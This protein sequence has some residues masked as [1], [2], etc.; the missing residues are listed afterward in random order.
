MGYTIGQILPLAVTLMAGPLPMLVILLILVSERAAAKGVAFVCGR[1]LGVAVCLGVMIVLFSDLG[2]HGFGHRDH[3][4]PATS[5]ARIVIGVVLL[6][7]AMRRWSR[8][9][10]DPGKPSPLMRRVDGLSPAGSVGIG[11]AVSIIDPSSLAIA[12]LAGVDIGSARMPLPS[13]VGVAAGFLLVSTATI[14]VPLIA[15]L[16]GGTG[17]RA[18]LANLKTWLLANEKAVTMVLLLL[19]A[20]MLIGRGISEL[21]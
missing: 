11:V 6:G 2:L 13:T 7:L 19:L 10:P 18:R 20:A 5:I 4:A 21:A 14:T 3:P 9:D 12:L 16:V 15:Y 8:P 1:L 17:A